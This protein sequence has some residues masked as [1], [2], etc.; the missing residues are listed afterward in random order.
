MLAIAAGE[1]LFDWEDHLQRLYIAYNMSV[2]PTT[3][4]TPFIL[5]FGQQI[6]MPIDIMYGTPNPEMSSPP[7][8]AA[9]LK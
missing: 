1:Y 4:Y 8:C 7:E 9:N 2:H 3:G 6:M 5:M